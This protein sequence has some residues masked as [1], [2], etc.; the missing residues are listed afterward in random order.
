MTVLSNFQ[1][2]GGTGVLIDCEQAADLTTL[3]ARCRC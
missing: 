1:K 3:K 2:L